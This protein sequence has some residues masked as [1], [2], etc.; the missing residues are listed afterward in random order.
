MTTIILRHLYL[1]TIIRILS[2]GWNPGQLTYLLQLSFSERIF[3][4]VLNIGSQRCANSLG[5][6]GFLYSFSSMNLI[7]H[8]VNSFL[9]LHQ[10]KST[11]AIYFLPNIT[12]PNHPHVQLPN[13][14]RYPLPHSRFSLHHH[15]L[16]SYLLGK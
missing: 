3:Y 4:E 8:S 9:H 11:G 13:I 15:L 14:Q 6:K 12:S 16:E 7:E 5:I 1:R 10:Q 2:N